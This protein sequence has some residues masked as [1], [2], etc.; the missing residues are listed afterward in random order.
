MMETAM[1]IGLNV[2]IASLAI[3]IVVRF[4]RAEADAK[5]MEMV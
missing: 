4:V 5:K 3:L 2:M 1:L